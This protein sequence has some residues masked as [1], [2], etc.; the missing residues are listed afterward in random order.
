MEHIEVERAGAVGWIWLARP[1]KLNAM[2]AGM[3][4]RLPEAVAELDA[5]PEI[6][7][8]VVAGRG[9]AFTVGI[10]L[11]MLASLRG[12]GSSQAERASKVYAGIKR[13]QDTMTAFERSPRPVIAA[14]HG[15]CLGAGVDLIT[16]CDIRISTEDAIFGVRETRMGLVADVGTTQRLPKVIAPGHMAEL[17]YTGRD[18]D[19]TE[20]ERIG[21][22]NHTYRDRDSLF[23][24][25]ASLATEIADNSPLVV[26]GI[27]RILQ[28]GERLP[29]DIAL[30][31]MAVW[32]AAFL[33]SNDLSEAMAAFMEKRTPRFTGT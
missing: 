21:L 13:L 29:T 12:E 5:D 3:W 16:A 15:Y 14:I 11:G 33:E 10:D 24:A 26:Q 23:E 30:E 1:E 31:H 22:V 7:V 32:N 2:A 27:K 17:L 25:A 20:A 18:I 4:A 28:T 9:D 8:V 19:G 6:R